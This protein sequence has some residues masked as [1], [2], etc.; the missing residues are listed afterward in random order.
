M[1]WEG[2]GEVGGWLVTSLAP[3][4]RDFSRGFPVV[5]P[6]GFQPRHPCQGGELEGMLCG[7][8]LFQAS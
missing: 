1:K 3:L 2:R 4:H 6:M 5:N 7:L 8:L